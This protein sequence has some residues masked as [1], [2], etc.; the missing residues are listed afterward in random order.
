MKSRV[1]SLCTVQYTLCSVVVV[2]CSAD[3]QIARAYVILYSAHHT[4]MREKYGSHCR[5]RPHRGPMAN[6]AEQEIWESTIY[7]YTHRYNTASNFQGA[8][9]VDVKNHS[10]VS[11]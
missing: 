11:R 4:R 3:S 1:V 7:E 2:Y 9:V 6:T 10:R 5:S 8:C